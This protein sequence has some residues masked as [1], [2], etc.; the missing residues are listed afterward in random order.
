MTI[1]NHKAKW[2]NF[3]AVTV[4]DFSLQDAKGNEMKIYLRTPPKSIGY[5][6]ATISHITVERAAEAPQP[7]TLHFTNKPAAFVPF[8]LKVEGIELRK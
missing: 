8:A 3:D 7:W 5:G 2:L 6:D 4:E 1:R